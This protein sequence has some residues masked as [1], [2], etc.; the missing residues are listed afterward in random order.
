[1]RQSKSGYQLKI[2]SQHVVALF[3]R[4]RI[5]RNNFFQTIKYLC[6]FRI[7]SI[8]FVI[9]FFFEIKIQAMKWN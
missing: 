5:T 4:R 6:N 2:L 7:I 1:M 8:L 3:A 9:L